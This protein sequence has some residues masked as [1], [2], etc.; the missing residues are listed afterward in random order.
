MFVG[1]DRESAVLRDRI[2]ATREGR[3]GVVLVSGPAGIGK[4]RVVEEV[5]ADEPYALRS[6][7]LAEVG[8]PPLWPWWRIFQRLPVD[9][10]AGLADAS[11]SVDAAQS[12]AER[13]RLLAD[14]TELLLSAAE[15]VRGLIV[16]LED[17]H[18]A[19]EASL[20]LLRQ[21]AR[22][23]ADSWLLLIGTHRDVDATSA[24]LAVTLA[25]VTR[26]AGM[27]VPLARFTVV[28]VADYLAGLPGSPA[29][30][31]LVHDRTGGLPLLV[32]AM[33]R[34]LDD[35]TRRGIEA[36][37]L[38]QY[39]VVEAG[40]KAPRSSRGE[41]AEARTGAAPGTGRPASRASRPR[42]AH[43]RERAPPPPR[44]PAPAP[45]PPRTRARQAAR[46]AR[47]PTP[48]S[49]CSFRPRS[50]CSGTPR[51]EER[52]RPGRMSSRGR[53]DR[54][55]P[56]ACGRGIDGNRPRVLSHVRHVAPVEHVDDAVGA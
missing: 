50:R 46:T 56:S 30:T 43:R 13:F 29:L 12:A 53:P 38:Q 23:A 19:D 21:V 55:I 15:E 2:A 17:V 40:D 6:R 39:V 49:S 25:E 44:R 10:P 16:V 20:A 35:Q 31:K 45:R 34:A 54:Q 22:E 1:R 28:E 33:A 42:R 26:A 24:G 4:S 41:A 36:T 11:G 52:R 18:D 8:V 9:L 48:S 51:P 27:T 3:G 32:A 5:L 14:L 7:C 47:T 37:P